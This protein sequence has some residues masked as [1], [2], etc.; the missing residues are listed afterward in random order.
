MPHVE[1]A[2]IDLP[3]FGLP[4]TEPQISDHIYAA[5]MEAARVRAADAGFDALLV[6]G[7]REHFANLAYLTKYDPRFE[8]ALLILVPG[9]T[10]ALLVGNEG[11][12][13][14]YICPLPVDRIL[15]QSFSLISQP[16]GESLPLR[17]IFENAGLRGRMC[18]GVAG[19]KYFIPVETETP[20]QWI[21]APAYIVDTLRAL[22]CETRNATALFMHPE[23]GLRAVN[24]VEQLARFEFVSTFS[25]QSVRNVL[26]G[27]R[28]GMTEF[29]V[30]ELMRLNGM[31]LSAHILM[32]SGER[33][34][35]GLASP[36]IRKLRRGDPVFTN[37]ALWGAN[38]ARGGFLVED[39]TELSQSIRDYVEELVAPYFAAVVE[40]YE[41]LGIG[42]TGGELYGIIRRHLGDA[43]FGVSL[44]PGHLIHLDEWLSSPVYEDSAEQ[45]RSGM[46]IQV[47]VIPATGSDYFTTNI[48]DTL[49]LA[50]EDLRAALQQQYPEAWARIERRRDFIRDVLG[51]RLK[52]EV[53][54]FSNI[55]AYLP[56]FW[57]APRRAMRVAR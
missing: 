5:R 17:A 27:V 42:T 37:L 30:T 25:S 13:Y 18:V 11:M 55:P 4:A 23:N 24:E 22:G 6:Y 35:L 34:R 7:D 28:A 2:E 15:Y 29:E 3:E 26:F 48:E 12:A 43:F 16:R 52:P 40:W 53:L 57:L 50:D 20:D 19:W 56:P 36:S 54:P 10:P 14:S 46:A 49:A 9:H 8:E 32:L 47:D 39:A 41:T 45:L 33:T 51:I 1:L 38:T 44:N 31:E 21:E